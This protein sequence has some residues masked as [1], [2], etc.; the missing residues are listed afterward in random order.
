[1]SVSQKEKGFL[2]CLNLSCDVFL[3]D[4][5]KNKKMNIL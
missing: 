3:W 2:I 1:M 4:E 5:Y